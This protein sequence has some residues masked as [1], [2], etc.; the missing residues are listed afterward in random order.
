M[1][2]H[3]TGVLRGFSRITCLKALLSDGAHKRS[4]RELQLL[5]RLS[6]GITAVSGSNTLPT[7]QDIRQG[8]L[9]L[10]AEKAQCASA[11]GGH[12]FKQKC[13]SAPIQVLRG[14]WQLP[15]YPATFLPCLILSSPH[16][17]PPPRP[18]QPRQRQRPEELPQT[19][20]SQ[21]Q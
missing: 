18:P 11:R 3:L 15:C 12:S 14:L 4:E 6:E 13:R 10:S 21:P 7:H 20:Q 5:P 1:P 17:H 19:P 9:G 2:A 8:T 16:L